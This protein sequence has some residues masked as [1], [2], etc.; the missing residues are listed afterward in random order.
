MT[1]D[2]WLLWSSHKMGWG[3]SILCRSLL[4]PLEIQ[5][6]ANSREY[7]LLEQH[8]QSFIFSRWCPSAEDE[9]RFLVQQF[10][11]V[12]GSHLISLLYICLGVQKIPVCRREVLNTIRLGQRQGGGF[13][14]SYRG[15]FLGSDFILTLTCFRVSS[16]VH[17]SMNHSPADFHFSRPGSCSELFTYCRRNSGVKRLQ[18]CPFCERRRLN[19]YFH[20]NFMSIVD[21]GAGLEK[22][23]VYNLL[24]PVFGR[25][26]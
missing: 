20:F 5:I 4:I 17:K 3:S 21:E 9:A 19:I 2:F 15:R 24:F 10:C 6:I 12:W 7:Q 16:S 1:R 11:Q 22:N 8:P 25:S 14:N 18:F 13:P 26:L 23:P